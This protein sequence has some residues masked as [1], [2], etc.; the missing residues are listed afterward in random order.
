MEYELKDLHKRN[1]IFLIITAIFLLLSIVVHFLTNSK[2]TTF[3]AVAGLPS[4]GLMIFFV[5]KKWLVKEMQY[6]GVFSYAFISFMVTWIEPNFA[7]FTLVYISLLAIS[8]YHNSKLIYF[9][10][11]LGLFNINFF[12][13][14][15]SE[16]IKVLDFGHYISLNFIFIFCAVFLIVQTKIGENINKNLSIKQ[17]ETEKA[18]ETIKEVFSEVKQ[19]I[20]SINEFQIEL[21]KKATSTEES[22]VKMLTL[23]NEM[24]SG[25]DIQDKNIKEIV[26]NISKTDEYV[27]NLSETTNQ[28]NENSENSNNVI[29]QG[30][31]KLNNLSDELKEIA[32]IIK[33]SVLYINELNKQNENVAQLLSGIDII[34]EQ[35]NLLSLNASIEAAR[36]GEHGRGF[37]VVAEEVKKLANDS[38]VLTDNINK[39]L[40]E[41]NKQNEKTTEQIYLGNE[42][43][44]Q[45]QHTIQ[46]VK[47]NFEEINTKNQEIGTQTEQLEKVVT[48]LNEYSSSVVQQISSI[49][50]ISTQHTAS[51]NEATK[52]LEEQ[53]IEIQD[54][55]EGFKKIQKSQDNLN[56]ILK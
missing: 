39:I 30:K 43:I 20:Q 54:V 10:S 34:T 26:S 53:T 49:S 16:F 31:N 4:V 1:T 35:I 41:A 36:A 46:D 44:E 2:T 8:V 55:F 15:D 3:I 12:Y 56:N 24:K 29:I 23:F 13:F 18:N 37:M 51:M 19:N 25:M 38:K 9:T 27:A 11:I 33:T 52:S 28:L 7:Y 22:S 6:I 40:K 5:K 14:N 47:R 17:K 42:K 21:D 48:A 45:N 32:Q 50:S